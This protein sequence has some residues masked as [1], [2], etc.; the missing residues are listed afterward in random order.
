M[1]VHS[2]VII[3]VIT[4]SDC[5]RYSLRNEREQARESECVLSKQSG[6]TIYGYTYKMENKATISV[7][8][9]TKVTCN[10]TRAARATR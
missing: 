9:I 3:F 1:W 4:A 2:N 8:E 5:F 7:L 10:H 6:I